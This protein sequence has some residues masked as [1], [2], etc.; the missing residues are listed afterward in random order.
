MYTCLGSPGASRRIEPERGII[1][2]GT[3]W[4]ETRGT[5]ANPGVER[6]GAGSPLA[7]ND[8]EM[9]HI[10]ELLRRDGTQGR[11]ERFADNHNSRSRIVEQEFIVGRF[12]QSVDGNGNG[13]DLDGSEKAGSK[14]RRIQQKQKDS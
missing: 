3:F 9:F 10:T 8:D 4:L 12:Q 11:E 7:A 1:L 6:L 14:L 13:S 5:I 2:A